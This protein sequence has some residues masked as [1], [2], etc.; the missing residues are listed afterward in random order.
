MRAA[1]DPAAWHA[2]AS[3]GVEVSITTRVGVAEVCTCVHHFHVL[4]VGLH[5]TVVV[6]VP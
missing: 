4:S 2:G 3:V 5:K 6:A 1:A